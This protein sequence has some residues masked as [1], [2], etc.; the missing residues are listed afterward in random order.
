MKRVTYFFNNKIDLPPPNLTIIFAVADFY[1]KPKSTG[2]IFIAIQMNM[3]CI[4]SCIAW[5]RKELPSKTTYTQ[6][7]KND[8]KVQSVSTSQPKCTW[9]ASLSIRILCLLHLFLTNQCYL[10]KKNPTT[11]NN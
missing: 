5:S 9:L 7:N 3:L 10:G 4:L 8:D 11:T 1:S 2:N 6:N